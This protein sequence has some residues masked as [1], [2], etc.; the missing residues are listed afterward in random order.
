MDFGE[1]K[2][3]GRLRKTGRGDLSSREQDPVYDYRLACAEQFE[4]LPYRPDFDDAMA[5]FAQ[6]QKI[7]YVQEV[8]VVLEPGDF[9]AELNDAFY[10]PDA[11]TIEAMTL[12]VNKDKDGN[13]FL[14]GSFYVGRTAY[15]VAPAFPGIAITTEANDG[16]TLTYKTSQETLLEL[17]GA[18]YARH[19]ARMLEQLHE[20]SLELSQEEGSEIVDIP[21]PTIT[22]QDVHIVVKQ[23]I[24]TGTWANITELFERLA[25]ETGKSSF[26][27]RS[28]FIPSDQTAESTTTER[29]I[30]ATKTETIHGSIKQ[31]EIELDINWF[32]GNANTEVIGTTA[33]NS[34]E[35][36]TT[37]V[38]TAM[39]Q[40]I[41]YDI[42]SFAF[43]KEL[44]KLT[45]NKPDGKRFTA[46]DPE[47]LVLVSIFM[48]TVRP[49][50]DRYAPNYE[51]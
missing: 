47:W 2:T 18:M 17:L 34:N 41:D 43:M 14:E 30:L 11:P 38:P 6:S 26:I 48:T 9:P 5:E 45:G 49:H 31:N 51:F 13:Q 50:L 20:Q 1:S 21:F 12:D 3:T 10:F 15:N 33:H 16:S 7:H 25:N 28:L 40:P 32:L 23:L 42:E 4:T 36:I 35:K 22:S 29:A 24:D 37:P 39:V 46:G 8:P 27:T 44:E 19:A